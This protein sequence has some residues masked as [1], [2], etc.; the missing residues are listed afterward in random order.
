VQSGNVQLEISKMNLTQ[1]LKKLGLD[2][3]NYRALVLL[4][5]VQVA[6]ADRRVQRAEKALI[7]K[8]AKQRNLLP[9]SA[10]E[11][12][13]GWME[14]RPSRQFFEL[15]TRVLVQMALLT[16]KKPG[17][18]S[19]T[20]QTLMDLLDDTHAVARAA[21]GMFGLAEPISR[22]ELQC[23]VEVGTALES[24]IQQTWIDTTV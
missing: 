9:D 11:V 13:F 12:V 21:G 4:P 23:L 20:T 8:I 16:E 5:L 7:L 1:S 6:W 3:T 2:R 10:R 14:T 22:K 19:I 17:A 18:T 24:G 15:G